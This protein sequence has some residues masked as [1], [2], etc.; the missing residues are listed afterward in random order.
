MYGRRQDTL[1]ARPAHSLAAKKWRLTEYPWPDYN[2]SATRGPSRPSVRSQPDPRNPSPRRRT[3][4][5]GFVSGVPELKF[6]MGLDAER[7]PRKRNRRAAVAVVV[8]T[9]G[10]GEEILVVRRATFPGDPWSGHIALPGGGA[11][12]FDSCLE[13]T[14]RRETLEETGIDLRDMPCVAALAPVSPQS[15]AAPLIS[16]A[17]FVFRYAGDKRVT[18][19]PEIVEAWWI[20]VTEFERPDAWQTTRFVTADGLAVEA[21]AF[22]IRGHVLWGL[23]ERILDEFLITRRTER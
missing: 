16:V 22:Q 4:R 9:G 2:G 12:P 10:V 18:M 23:T 11:E 21:R 3:A 20:P 7:I 17:P 14:A 15:K 19:S 6:G 8:A 13:A 5:D 1:R